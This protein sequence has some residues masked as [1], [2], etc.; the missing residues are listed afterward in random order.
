MG[1]ATEPVVHDERAARSTGLGP[2]GSSSPAAAP[3]AGA[4]GGGKPTGPIPGKHLQADTGP[5][6][7]P[8]GGGSGV[9]VWPFVLAAV[10]LLLAGSTSALARWLGPRRRWLSASTDAGRASVAWREFRDYLTDYGIASAPSESP[11]AVARRV[12]ADAQ[13][14]DAASAAITRIGGAEERARYSQ[15]QFGAAW[16]GWRRRRRPHGPPGARGE[17]DQAPAAARPLPAAVDDG[18][19]V[20]WSPVHRPRAQLA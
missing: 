3:S 18:H 8:G 9:P 17:R 1:T 19:P 4:A 10:L 13:L 16:A 6:G 14:D 15:R 2:T 5:A 12:A 11:R 7:T 20:Q